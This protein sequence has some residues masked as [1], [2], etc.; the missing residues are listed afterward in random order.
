MLLDFIIKWT[1]ISM[2]TLSRFLSALTLPYRCRS[3]DP[4]L[5]YYGLTV[6][7]PLLTPSS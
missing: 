1:A 4:S 2:F 5:A 6:R 3:Y 7:E